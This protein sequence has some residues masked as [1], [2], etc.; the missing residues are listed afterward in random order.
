MTKGQLWGLRLLNTRPLGQGDI[1]CQQINQAG[2]TVIHCPTLEILPTNNGW[3][4]KLPLLKTINIAIFISVN[5]V[6]HAFSQLI[7][8]H[9]KWPDTIHVIAIGK[10]TANALQQHGI[11]VHDI[12]AIPN[13]EH[14]L[15]L[16]YLKKQKHSMLLFKGIGGLALIEQTLSKEH[17]LHILEVYQRNI[18]Q[19][20]QQFTEELWRE[21]AVDIILITSEQSLNNLFAL[22]HSNTHRWLKSKTF[23]VLSE[24]LANAASELGIKKIRVSHPEY[25]FQNLLD[26]VQS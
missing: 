24:R 18:P 7:E 6:N 21:N 10:T 22:F 9:I 8:H 13:S 19:I 23:V 15:K 12:P 3:V 17:T 25:L 1:L 26:F 5:A 16:A 14:L 11:E 2:G 4:E 20:N